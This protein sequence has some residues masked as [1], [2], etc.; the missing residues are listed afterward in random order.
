MGRDRQVG[1][2]AGARGGPGRHVLPAL[3]ERVVEARTLEDEELRGPGGRP[4]LVRA[5]RQD[6]LV[7]LRDYADAIES[8]SWPVPRSILL[9][10]QLHQALVGPTTTR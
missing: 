8:L 3:L 10:I 6:T 2:V 9:D 4:E 1:S 5:A 7:A